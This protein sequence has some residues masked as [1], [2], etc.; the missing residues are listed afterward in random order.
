MMKIEIHINYDIENKILTTEDTGIGMTKEDLIN[1]LEQSQ[2]RY[3]S[4]YTSIK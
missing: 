3:C 1:N 4:I 2:I